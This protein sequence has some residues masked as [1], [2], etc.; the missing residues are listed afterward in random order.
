MDNIILTE[1]EITTI[2]ASLTSIRDIF[3][4]SKSTTKADLQVEI[5]S[6]LAKLKT[7]GSA[8]RLTP[9]IVDTNGNEVIF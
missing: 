2:I 7:V 5:E 3:A 1:N 6:A 8:V 4:L 9:T